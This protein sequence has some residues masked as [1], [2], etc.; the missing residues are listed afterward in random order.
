[1]VDAAHEERLSL[2]AALRFIRLPWRQLL[3]HPPQNKPERS[4]SL[5]VM[6]LAASLGGQVVEGGRW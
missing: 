5:A 1:M 4:P 2:I 6:V 3:E